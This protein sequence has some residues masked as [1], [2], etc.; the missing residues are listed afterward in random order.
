MIENGPGGT[1]GAPDLLIAEEATGRLWPV[2]LKV[3]DL[4]SD[5]KLKVREIRPAQIRMNAI[6]IRYQVKLLFI[7]GVKLRDGWSSFL[8]SDQDL[9]NT[10]RI[11]EPVEIDLSKPFTDTFKNAKSP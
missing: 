4:T 1:P 6:L 11:F 2:E 9:A 5:Q 10:R 8:I 7:A 3:A